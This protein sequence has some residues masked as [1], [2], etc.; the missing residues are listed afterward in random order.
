MPRHPARLFRFLVPLLLNP[1]VHQTDLEN[2]T[3]VLLSQWGFG[4]FVRVA[5]PS[6]MMRATRKG[7]V[8]ARAHRHRGLRDRGARDRAHASVVAW[9]L[10]GISDE[11]R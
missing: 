5:R 2:R 6:A 4:G 9:Y 11:D 10:M 8:H 3:N 7:G 1:R